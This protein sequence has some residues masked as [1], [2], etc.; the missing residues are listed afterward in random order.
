MKISVLKKIQDL[1]LPADLDAEIS[2]DDTDVILALRFPKN[3]TNPG[4]EPPSV[5]VKKRSKRTGQAS[6][7]LK[8]T[9]DILS[10]FNV[11]TPD[12]EGP[13]KITLGT[14]TIEAIDLKAGVREAL[15]KCGIKEELLSSLPESEGKT[16]IL[17][18]LN[19]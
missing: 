11:S 6:M 12:G 8:G 2:E 13:Q 16:R 5:P 19:R 15:A 1:H 14:V 10:T 3:D 4:P 7:D 17:G 18:I 9:K